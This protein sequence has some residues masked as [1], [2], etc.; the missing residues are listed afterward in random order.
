MAK[1]QERL[2]G[3]IPEERERERKVITEKGG[4]VISQ[5]T[6]KQ[7]Y[8]GMRGVKCLVCDTSSLDPEEGISFRG[9]TIPQLMERLPKAPKGD[10]P[11][12]EAHWWLLLTGELPTEEE[13]KDLQEELKSRMIVPQYVF[14]MLDAMPEDTH[15]MTM[16]SAAVLS[17][18]GESL[19][20]KRYNEG[21]KRGDY[22]EPMYEDSL[23]LLAKLPE[24]GAHIYRMK[25]KGGSYIQPDPD[26]DWGGNFAH[27]MGVEKPEYKDLMRLYFFLHSDHESG[28]VSAH[29]GHLV[30]SALSDVYYSL[31]AAL[32][33]LAGPLHGLANQMC[34]KWIM[35][36]M[37]K[38]GGTPTKEQVEKYAWD[39]LNSGQVIPGYGHAV[40]RKTD[41][42]FVAQHEFAMRYCPD[43]PIV[44]TVTR[45]YEVVPAILQKHGKAKNP[46]PNVDAHSG[47]LQYHYGI[48]EFDFYTVFFG[49]GRALGITAELVWDRAL[50]L[51]IERPKSVTTKWIEEEA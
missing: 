44:K 20:V 33:G 16:F 28:N 26:L 9:Y 42:R 29:T 19:F 30:A 25:Y 22:W 43:D 45:V 48:R 37:D 4:K 21:M 13:V 2:Q 27:M 1:L 7:A 14:K 39:T 40:L 35:E 6:V 38:L 12:P 10:S 15:P 49:I 46:W 32:N 11:L 8:G 3:I 50:I 18:Q 31:S 36:M 23:N 51:P 41:P 17:M 24:I 47:C 5:V 34:L